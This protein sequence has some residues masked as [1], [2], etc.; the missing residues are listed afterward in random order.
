MAEFK[1]F[2]PDVEV[3]GEVINAFSTGFPQEVRAFG[4]SI[5]EKYGLHEAHAGAFYPVQSLLDAMKHVSEDLG[6]QMLYRIGFQ[7]AT[8]AILPPGIDSLEKCLQSIDVAYHMNHRSGEIGDY[9]FVPAETQRFVHRVK[10]ECRNPYPCSFDIGV[11]EGFAT[12]F[13]PPDC[14]DVLVRHDETGPCRKKGAESCAYIVSW[15]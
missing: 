6:P 4:T 11:I 9:K 10:M 1:S 12:R 15:A 14:V 5:L 8:N 7:I 2:E 3:A 13:K